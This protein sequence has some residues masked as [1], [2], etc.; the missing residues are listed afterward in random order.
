MLAAPWPNSSPP[1]RALHAGQGYFGGSAGA[2]RAVPAT[3]AGRGLM[4]LG[5]HNT[6]EL[7]RYAARRGLLS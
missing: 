6:A 2:L 7:V 4:E 3:R 1:C 5:A